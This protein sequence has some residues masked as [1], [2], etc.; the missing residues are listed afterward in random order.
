MVGANR[1]GD[2]GKVMSDGSGYII[3]LTLEI[4]MLMNGKIANVLQ[5]I[6]RWTSQ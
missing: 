4:R 3:I 1:E 6:V 5:R 2:E